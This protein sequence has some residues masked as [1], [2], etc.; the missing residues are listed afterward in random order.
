MAYSIE[1][2]TANR[3]KSDFNKTT[4]VSDLTIIRFIESITTW[5][6][7]ARINEIGIV[8]GTDRMIPEEDCL[9]VMISSNASEYQ[10]A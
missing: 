3:T 10:S 7:I 4:L 6:Y 9:V 1:L 5:I 2:V 8:N